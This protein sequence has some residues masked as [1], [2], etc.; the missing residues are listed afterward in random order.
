MA[1][2]VDSTYSV[3]ISFQSSLAGS[4][5]LL[6]RERQRGDESA[7]DCFGSRSFAAV[8]FADALPC[9][10]HRSATLDQRGRI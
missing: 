1:V 9:E 8:T 7:C 10:S 3:V 4:V 2:I 6:D 5:D